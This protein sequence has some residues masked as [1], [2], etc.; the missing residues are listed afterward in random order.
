[1][2]SLIKLLIILLRIILI[3]F[4]IFGALG[5]IIMALQRDIVGV[6]IFIVWMLL[7]IF[8]LYLTFR[9]KKKNDSSPTIVDVSQQVNA[10]ISD[11]INTTEIEEI[12]QASAVI[13]LDD[14]SLASSESGRLS[15]SFPDSYVVLD[16]E[17]PNKNN[18]RISQIGLLFVRNGLIDKN[19][20]SLI[21]PETGFNKIN[22]NLTNISAADVAQSPTFNDYWPHIKS[23]LENN[24]IV[25]HNA[26]FDLTVLCKTL[27]H[28]GI[29]LPEIRYVCTYTESLNMIPELSKHNLAALADYFNISQSNAHNAEDDAYTCYLV[30]E[31]MKSHGY[32]F[33]PQ[34][35]D[36]PDT[37]S[38]VASDKLVYQANPNSDDLTIDIPYSKPANILISNKKFVL[39]GIFSTVTKKDITTYI[40]E[41]GGCVMSSVSGRTNYLLVGSTPEP[42]WAHGNYGRK[43]EKAI[44]LISQGK[45]S[46]LILS[47]EYFTELIIRKES[48]TAVKT[49]D[50]IPCNN[51]SFSKSGE[52]PE[53][54]SYDVTG[55]VI[56]DV[57]T[58]EKTESIPS[59][60][61]ETTIEHHK[62]A[63]TS[64]R[65]NDIIELGE[66]N[67]CYTWT[68]KEIVE[69]GMEDENIYQLIFSPESVELIE[70]P[71]NEYDPNA[72]KV[73]ID[74]IHV[75]YIKKGSCSHIKKLIK[76]NK[77][78][79]I[80]GEILGGKYKRVSSDYDLMEDKTTYSL[81]RDEHD[82]FVSI[83]L[84]IKL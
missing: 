82:F 84:K 24:V 29:N 54:S 72:V 48:A 62:L 75:G 71:D 7:G 26:S 19:Y 47:E 32:E 69:Y 53:Q 38:L 76:E 35:F 10:S 36:C 6:I 51:T 1:M 11:G 58:I 30:F 67:D 49:C 33:S 40:E 21:N 80:T 60:S 65:Q 55:N 9:H 14:S 66:E 20:S 15:Y 78:I 22:V 16:F 74:G 27:F 17:T 64:F 63:G 25:A 77:I 42:A 73:V 50:K 45:S 3:P 5:I 61:L 59:A 13:P 28:Y 83:Y 79:E 2:K 31:K 8:P 44:E 68:K 52:T 41:N 37:D 57:T 39:T 4:I 70:E 43:L 81:E 18:N 34:I 46:P 23:L 12:P 56:K